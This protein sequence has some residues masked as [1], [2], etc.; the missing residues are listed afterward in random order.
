MILITPLVN[1]N[2]QPFKNSFHNVSCKM[3]I[4]KVQPMTIA[5]KFYHRTS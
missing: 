1:T 5:K 3:N 2:K 4:K